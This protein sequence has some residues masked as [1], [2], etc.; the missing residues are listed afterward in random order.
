[1]MHV[2][3]D[4]DKIRSGQSIIARGGQSKR[5][6]AICSALIVRFIRRNGL[7]RVDLVRICFASYTG[8]MVYC[9][10][11]VAGGRRWKGLI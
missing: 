10:R 5:V 11:R 7:V 1:M 3:I 4:V 2:V 6:K 9:W 8:G